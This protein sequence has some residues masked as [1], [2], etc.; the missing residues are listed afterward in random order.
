MST[1][2]NR[3]AWIEKAVTA[4]RVHFKE[5][6]WTI[7]DNVRISVGIP[8]GM[9]GSKK[10]I[11]QCWS[12]TVT[13]DGYY[14][15]F[16][17]P[18][19]GKEVDHLETIAHE[20]VHATVGTKEG[21][22]GKFKVCAL[23]VGFVSPMTSTPAGEKMKNTIQAIINSIG[24]Y[25]AGALDISQRKKKQTYMIKCQCPECGYVVRTTAQWLA[26]GDPICPVDNVGM[27]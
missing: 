16:T 25:P 4:F 1:S 21:H 12:D 13:S 14:E 24:Y 15:I 20:L 11:G 5:C 7:P 17:S 3:Q 9:H 18:E 27:N 23:D 10:A 6:G 26:Q 8:K 19:Q 22:R 2:I